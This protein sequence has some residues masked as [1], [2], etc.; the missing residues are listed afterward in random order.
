MKTLIAE[1]PKT[2]LI[3]CLAGR[4]RT[5]NR[6]ARGRDYLTYDEVMDLIAAARKAKYG[7]RDALMIRLAF[8]HGFRVAELVALRWNQVQLEGRS[9][10]LHV[11]RVK[12]GTPS[13]HFLTGTEVRELRKLRRDYP[14][15]DY[16]FQTQQGGTMTT[17][18]FHKIVS[19]AAKAAGLP[20]AV[21]PHML[22]HSIG[23]HLA[24]AGKDA[25]L[26]QDFLGHKNI[27]HTVRYT[28]LNCYKFLE[29]MDIL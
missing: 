3:P 17:R 11:N 13:I 22:R 8:D 27:Q 15:G 24:N 20:F 6:I 14:H 1:T 23:Y 5:A 9:F 26:I 10:R 12:K 29:V 25:R 4:V 28:Q 7:Q 2:E 18:A 16:V 21:H 19:L